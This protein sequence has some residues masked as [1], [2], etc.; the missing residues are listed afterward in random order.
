M[1]LQNKCHH[2]SLEVSNNLST[3]QDKMLI[4]LFFY[5]GSIT[6]Y[7]GILY[8][9]VQSEGF[10]ELG[11]VMEIRNSTI[12]FLPSNT[13]TLKTCSQEENNS[14]CLTFHESREIISIPYYWLQSNIVLKNLLTFYH[15]LYSDHNCPIMVTSLYNQW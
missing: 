5:L 15:W 8:Y 1:K 10:E 6:F 7:K 14:T 4:W 13:K 9:I 12:N 11:Y 3:M 2:S